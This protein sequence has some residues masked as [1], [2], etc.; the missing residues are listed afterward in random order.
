MNKRPPLLTVEDSDHSFMVGLSSEK[1]DDKIEAGAIT[2]AKYSCE[3]QNCRVKS[4]SSGFQKGLFRIHLGL[5][6]QR[7]RINHGPFIHE[8]IGS[9]VN[10]ATGG[11]DES[12]NTVATRD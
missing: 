5:T 10:T 6:V 12:L 7:Y 9:P 3:P 2:V 1:I 8:N 11:K 4:G